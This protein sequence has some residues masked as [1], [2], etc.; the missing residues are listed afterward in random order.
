VGR[1]GVERSFERVSHALGGGLDVLW[2]VPA[3]A[4][5]NRMPAAAMA[6][7]LLSGLAFLVGAGGLGVTDAARAVP[8]VG[9][10]PGPSSGPIESVGP[11]GSGVPVASGTPIASGSPVAS[12]TPGVSGTPGASGVSGATGSPGSEPSFAPVP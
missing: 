9:N 5:T 6:V 2:L 1:S 8:V 7:L 4:R 11:G 12:G 10:G 3:A